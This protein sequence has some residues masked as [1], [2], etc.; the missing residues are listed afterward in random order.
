MIYR[1]IVLI[2]N[3]LLFFN[4]FNV[5]ILVNINI[6]STYSI[7]Y[8]VYIIIMCSSIISVFM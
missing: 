1:I 3:Y 7:Y 4:Q 6:L 8:R 2:I 5:S